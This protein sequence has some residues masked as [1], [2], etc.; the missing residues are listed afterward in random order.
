MND[1]KTAHTETPWRIAADPSPAAQ[2][3]EARR[4]AYFANKYIATT[5][6]LLDADGEPQGEVVC[7]MMDGPNQVA[8]AQLILTAVNEH[9]ALVRVHAAVI[10]MRHDIE[11]MYAK[12]RDPGSPYLK[13][14]NAALA[15]AAQAGKGTL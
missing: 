1:K 5:P 11:I 2:H 7:Q 13:E 6:E 8:N 14:L 15:E 3:P 10:A 12:H 9:T 4:F